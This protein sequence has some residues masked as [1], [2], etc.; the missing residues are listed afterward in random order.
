MHALIL[1][2]ESERIGF[3]V[4]QE[5]EDF[6]IVELLMA[7]IVE[8]YRNKGYGRLLISWAQKWYAD[9]TIIHARCHNE[10]LIMAHLLKGQRFKII[11]QTDKGTLLEYVIPSGQGRFPKLP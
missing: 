2:Y 9:G 10:S 4:V 6:S 7:G 11:N 5:K 8:R 1:K 3:L